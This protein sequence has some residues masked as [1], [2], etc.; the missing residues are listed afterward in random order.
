MIVF[1]RN[2]LIKIPK[3]DKMIMLQH[4]LRCEWNDEEEKKHNLSGMLVLLIAKLKKK[5]LK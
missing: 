1:T 4:V 5:H 3:F 2:E